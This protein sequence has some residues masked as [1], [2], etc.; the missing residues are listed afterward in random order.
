MC[1]FYRTYGQSIIRSKH[2]VKVQARFMKGQEKLSGSQYIFGT[3]VD[4]VLPYGESLAGKGVPVA[5]QLAGAA[6]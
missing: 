4:I 2:C 1:I 5:F 3:V 6:V